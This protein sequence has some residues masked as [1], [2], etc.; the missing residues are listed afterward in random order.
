VNGDKINF[1]P[2]CCFLQMG[3]FYKCGRAPIVAWIILGWLILLEIINSF[4]NIYS[5]RCAL[6]NTGGPLNNTCN[7]FIYIMMIGHWTL[8][9][10]WS[11]W[12]F[13]LERAYTVFDMTST[14]FHILSSC[15]NHFG[16]YSNRAFLNF[17][18]PNCCWIIK[19]SHTSFCKDQGYKPWIFQISLLFSL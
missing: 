19:T 10:P 4:N 14:S 13:R 3:M 6:V 9:P 17:L 1:F 16:N 11:F 12:F 5:L 2:F 8:W 18:S 7:I 15:W